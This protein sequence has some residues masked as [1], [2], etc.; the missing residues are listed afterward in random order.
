MIR[1]KRIL[2]KTSGSFRWGLLA[3]LIGVTAFLA[4][5]NA[6]AQQ[7]FQFTNADRTTHPKEAFGKK[8]GHRLQQVF[9]TASGPLEG[10]QVTYKEYLSRFDVVFMG[11]VN[12]KVEKLR[13]NPCDTPGK[14]K[15]QYNIPT[16]GVCGVP[17][18][19]L[20][21][22]FSIEKA[23]K[24]VEGDAVEMF[25][26]DDS[27]AKAY[28][29]DNL[30]IEF[31]H[32][33]LVYGMKNRKRGSLVVSCKTKPAEDAE[34]EMMFLTAAANNVDEAR[35]YAVLPR[36]AKTHSRGK[37]RADALLHLENAPPEM[38]LPDLKED[39]IFALRDSNRKV[40]DLAFK[41]LASD[42]YLFKTGV[43]D[44]LVSA[45]GQKYSPL[46]PDSIQVFAASAS[47]DEKTI[48]K[49]EGFLKQEKI[50]MERYRNKKPSAESEYYQEHFE[51][52]KQLL[53]LIKEQRN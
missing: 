21:Y 1:D 22:V 26:E 12:E 11:Q 37:T 45:V 32:Q 19:E 25:Y 33:Y 24:G 36:V 49:I 9:Q 4:V 10:E 47:R 53:E 48:A 5:S 27:M 39:L 20:Y 18:K 8:K 2:E 23:F 52:L 34:V 6:G 46:S 43:L 30:K 31:G 16:I 50:F 13:E 42:K 17:V 44:K 3:G 14:M 15:D 28:P 7:V 38:Q 51:G 29:C 40:R 35:I 41:I